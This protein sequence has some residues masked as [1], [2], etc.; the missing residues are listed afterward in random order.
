MIKLLGRTVN[1]L[2][3][4]GDEDVAKLRKLGSRKQAFDPRI[5]EW[6]TGEMNSRYSPLNKIG[7]YELTR[8]VNHL[9]YLEENKSRDSESSGE[10]NRTAKPK[11]LHFGVVGRVSR[12]TNSTAR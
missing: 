11:C 8:E 6:E 9:K 1:A 7:G 5:S 12:V 4:E 3:P 2:A 10:R